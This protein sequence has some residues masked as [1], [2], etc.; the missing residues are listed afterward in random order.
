M[1]T[2]P[3]LASTY[4]PEYNN[5]SPAL[6]TINYPYPYPNLPQPVNYTPLL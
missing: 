6:K 2:N 1:G 4:S 5:I 3:P